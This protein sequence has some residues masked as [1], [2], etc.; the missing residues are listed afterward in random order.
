[1][2]T[3]PIDVVRELCAAF[4]EGEPDLDHVLSF[5]ADSGG[6]HT[7]PRPAHPDDDATHGRGLAL[8]AA[9]ATR[10]HIH[11][12]HHGHTITAELPPIPRQPTAAGV[13]TC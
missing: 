3:A 7:T 1:M 4:G 12:D 6:T 2:S 9:L 8:V 13:S 10:L 11:G 5:F